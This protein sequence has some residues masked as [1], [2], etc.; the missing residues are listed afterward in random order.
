MWRCT[1]SVGLNLAAMGLVCLLLG[2]SIAI[3]S[4]QSVVPSVFRDG[5]MISVALQLP[6]YGKR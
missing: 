2:T 4:V 3:T 6:S 1:A 5:L